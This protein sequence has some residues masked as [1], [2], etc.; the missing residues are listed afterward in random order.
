M[1]LAKLAALAHEACGASGINSVTT[2]ESAISAQIQH[3]PQTGSLLSVTAW[4]ILNTAQAESSV[5][6]FYIP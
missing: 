5:Y 3:V 4:R 2:T 1:L 6:G